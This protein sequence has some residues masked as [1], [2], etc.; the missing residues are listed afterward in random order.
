[1]TSF[2]LTEALRSGLASEFFFISSNL[3]I[4]Y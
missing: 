2:L 4:F 1:L 3:T